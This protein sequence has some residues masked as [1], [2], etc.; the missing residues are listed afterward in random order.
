M[1][2]LAVVG[3]VFLSLAALAAPLPPELRNPNLVVNG[4]FE[5]GP[6]VGLMVSLGAKSEDIKGWKVT[7]GTIDY[8]GNFWP[9]QDG[10]RSVDLHGSPGLGGV[11]QTI[12][13]KKDVKYVLTFYL[14]STPGCAKPKKSLAV[15]IDKAKVD[16]D[17]DSTGKS[18][19]DWKE[20]KVTFVAKGDETVIEF[21]TLETED[22]NCGPAIDNVKVV[23]AK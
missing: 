2:G 1:R 22:P 13:T 8:V 21:Y 15:E 16:F 4:S 11:Q 5:D 12:K 20:Q 7:R 19:M 3:I 6:K 18:Q 17:C 10:K 9:H 23:R 14:S